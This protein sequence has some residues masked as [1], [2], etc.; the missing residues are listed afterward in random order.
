MQ[1]GFVSMGSI[2]LSIKQTRLGPV[3]SSPTPSDISDKLSDSIEKAKETCADENAK[4]ECAAAWDE[5]EELS[6]T[7]KD[8]RLKADKSDPLEEYCKDN[9]ETDECRTYDD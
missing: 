9:P 4:G 8:A 2:K 3:R 1:M 6:A 7:A 5:V